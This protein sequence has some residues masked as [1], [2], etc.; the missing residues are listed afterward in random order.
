MEGIRAKAPY[1]KTVILTTRIELRQP[2]QD[3][4]QIGGRM[5]AFQFAVWLEPTAHDGES[6][7]VGSYVAAA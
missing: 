4:I 5:P 2:G 3:K 1:N 7:T 6:C